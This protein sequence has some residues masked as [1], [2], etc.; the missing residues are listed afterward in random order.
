M[1]IT[2]TGAPKAVPFE[3]DIQLA[4]IIDDLCD[5]GGGAIRFSPG[6]YTFEHG[7]HSRRRDGVTGI[8]F[9]GSRGTIFRFRKLVEFGRVR[10]AADAVARGGSLPVDH[11]DLI[12]PGRRYQ[13]LRPDL[14]GNRIGEFLIT[15]KNGDSLTT[16]Q[17]E[18]V[19]VKTFP[20]G[21]WLIPHINFFDTLHW[22]DISFTDILF[23]GNFDLT[24]DKLGGQPFLGH[25]THGG[26][27]FRNPYTKKDVRR[28]H[29]SKVRLERCT[30]RSL[31]GRGA[32][33]YNT[34]DITLR[35]CRFEGCRAE[36]IEI[37]HLSENILIDG[38]EVKDARVAIRLN[39]CSKAIVRGCR[40]QAT[41]TGI[42]VTK[43]VEHEGVN[44]RISVTGNVIYDVDRGLVVDADS[45]ENVFTGNVFSGC[46]RMG[47]VI[48]GPAN[49]FAGNSVTGHFT[50][51]ILL[52]APRNIIENNYVA[53]SNSRFAAIR[54]ID[55]AKEK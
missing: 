42:H 11:P 34:G 41:K 50:T 27:L 45:T 14:R 47:I 51:G 8:D 43:V 37:D 55:A 15:G 16:A 23:D 32:T 3:S 28:P 1:T 49:V 29:T 9:V 18:N 6:V 30:F 25:T 17:Y 46:R 7:I 35:D 12:E 44:R 2:G 4:K 13:V 39:D 54:R 53:S 38:C 48:K 40:L 52:T 19:S 33:F 20:K 36:A 21:A 24:Q 10:I 5:A 22:A 26:V 31:L